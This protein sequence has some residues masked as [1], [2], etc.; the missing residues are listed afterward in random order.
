MKFKCAGCEQERDFF[1]DFVFMTT[2][3]EGKGPNLKFC[4][5]CRTV[6]AGFP[7]IYWDGSPEENLKNDPIT[8]KLPVFLSKGQKAAYL[9]ERG[10]M[11]AG[12]RVHGAPVQVSANNPN[13]V[14]DSRNEVKMA[15][16][17][18]MEMGKDQ[19]HQSYLKLMK[20]NRDKEKTRNGPPIY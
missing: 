11:E 14:F 2:S 4:R 19:R 3:K 6:R 16:K 15:M 1:K 12:D 10:M 13:P 9:K 18:V 8:G 5:T 17:K 7:D 20:E